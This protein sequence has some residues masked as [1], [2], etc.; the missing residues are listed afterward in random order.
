MKWFEMNE[1]RQDRGLQ[2]SPLVWVRSTDELKQHHHLE[3]LQP[4]CLWRRPHSH[5]VWAAQNHK[6]PRGREHHMVG[7]T[8][9]SDHLDFY[10]T[11]W[12]KSH[13]YSCEAAR[14]AADFTGSMTWTLLVAD[15]FKCS[16]EV[17]L[18]CAVDYWIKI[19]LSRLHRVLKYT[20]PLWGA[21][22]KITHEHQVIGLLT[23][24][25]YTN[26]GWILKWRHWSVPA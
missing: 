7:L 3:C 11:I 10:N 1:T 12:K 13:R 21:V 26:A 15:W 2:Y 17:R 20:V 8:G 25:L 19:D 14:V 16:L 6:G 9:L 24:F 22:H 4:A 23:Y 18:F 5:K